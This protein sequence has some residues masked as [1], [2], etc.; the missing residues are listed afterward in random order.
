MKRLFFVLTLIAAVLTQV[1]AQTSQL[2]TLLHDGNLSIFYGAGALKDAHEAAVAGDV[3]TL[4]AGQFNACTL[5]K[6]VTIRGAGMGL[7][8][9]DNFAVPTVL[10]GDFSITIPEDAEHYLV[11]EGIQHNTSIQISNVY[12]PQFIKC[13][14]G[15]LSIIGNSTMKDAK[16]IHCDIRNQISAS[17]NITFSSTNSHIVIGSF[18]TSYLTA[19][20]Q[21]CIIETPSTLYHSLLNNCIIKGLGS[22]TSIKL[23]GNCTPFYCVWYGAGVKQPFPYETAKGT[24]TRLDH[25]NVFKEGTFYE[26]TDEIKALKTSDGTQVGIYGGNMPFEQTTTVPQISKFSVAPKTSADGKLSIDIEVEGIKQ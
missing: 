1:S 11:L 22:S 10:T 6:P 21:N 26:L 2:A 20:Y 23:N 15:K 7:T 19:N 18:S 13:I 25:E 3:I 17:N 9:S 14:L 16:F 4:S 8:E 24:N 5:T 12:N